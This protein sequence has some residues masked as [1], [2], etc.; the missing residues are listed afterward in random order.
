M[1][2]C[3]TKAGRPQT[4]QRAHEN[5]KV[6]FLMEI[7]LQHFDMNENNAFKRQK[8]IPYTGKHCI[9]RTGQEKLFYADLMACIAYV[10]EYNEPPSFVVVAGG[11]PGVHFIKLIKML[12][13]TTQWHLY[14]P[15]AFHNE[16][17]GIANVYLYRQLYTKKD[18][19]KWV[20][21]SKTLFLSDIR[22]VNYT[23]T[24]E[25]MQKLSAK[26][27]SIPR[28][29]RDKVQGNMAMDLKTQLR[30]LRQKIEDMAFEDMKNQA[31]MI[32]DT[33]AEMSFVKF[34][35]PY[36]F[37]NT[38]LFYSY[39]K[40]RV[41]FQAMNRCNS[42]ECRL[43][44][45]PENAHTFKQEQVAAVFTDVMYDALKHEEQCAFINNNLRPEW[46]KQGI[47]ILKDMYS[48]FYTN[49]NHVRSIQMSIKHRTGM[50]G[51]SK[52]KRQ[53][54]VNENNVD[55]D[56]VH[57]VIKACNA[58]KKNIEFKKKMATQNIDV[59]AYVLNLA[60]R[61]RAT[62]Q[63]P[64]EFVWNHLYP[65]GRVFVSQYLAENGVTDR[66]LNVNYVPAPPLPEPSP[67]DLSE[68]SCM[69]ENQY[70][71]TLPAVSSSL[72]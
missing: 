15:E 61:P 71:V 38:P 54:I 55:I 56:L 13:L 3:N 8:Y 34:R 51:G 58:R 52:Q 32:K 35:L 69:R 46:D 33:E 9:E 65:Q 17:A 29:T 70:F 16:L 28:H 1:C 37:D 53:H 42:T 30:D 21:Q 23:P 64:F 47:K 40:G 10:C 60:R 68:G 67:E 39:L 7:M 18:C 4:T 25:I 41:F 48:R 44:V 2:L 59:L 62:F 12:P 19:S 6:V 11:A 31:Q 22:N 26:L 45:I 24:V 72:S 27:R 36:A 43:M 63:D 5:I 20:T 66:L 57:A 14:D 49:F 50:S